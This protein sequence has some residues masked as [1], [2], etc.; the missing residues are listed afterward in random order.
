METV[1][2]RSHITTNKVKELILDWYGSSSAYPVE[3]AVKLELQGRYHGVYEVHFW[4][5]V[6]G[7]N[8][9]DNG[10][11]SIQS[12]EININGNKVRYD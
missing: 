2:A 12:K 8:E 5:G 9:T 1:E 3:D 7:K 4:N 10:W 6:T 11:F